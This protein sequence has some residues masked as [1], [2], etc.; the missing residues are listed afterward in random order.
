MFSQI[1]HYGPQQPQTFYEGPIDGSMSDIAQGK[2]REAE[3]VD[4]F[5]AAAFE[6]AFADASAEMMEQDQVHDEL[7]AETDAM[8]TPYSGM[9]A[10]LQTNHLEAHAHREAQMALDL[11]LQDMH[12]GVAPEPFYSEHLSRMVDEEK[13]RTPQN[14]QQEQEEQKQQQQPNNDADELAQTARQLLES[15]SDNMSEK[16]QQSTFLALMRQLR[17]KEVTVQGDKMVNMNELD[18]RDVSA[19]SLSSSSNITGE[20]LPPYFSGPE[21]ATATASSTPASASEPISRSHY[22]SPEDPW[23]DM[24]WVDPGVSG[25]DMDTEMY[26]DA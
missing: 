8:A 11:D 21:I 4:A 18:Q 1:S 12:D 22:I 20:P 2:Q 26:E 14:E 9:E 16:F 5:D 25:A 17:D 19:P 7:Q 6:Q 13:M 23:A 10:R 3:P 15:V 24:S